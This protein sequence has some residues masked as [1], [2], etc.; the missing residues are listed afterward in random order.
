MHRK[1]FS[2]LIFSLCDN[3]SSQEK[4]HRFASMQ[5][6]SPG[7]SCMLGHLGCAHNLETG[8]PSESLSLSEEDVE[9]REHQEDI[10]QPE[11]S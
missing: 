9:D 10:P 2:P 5:K 3:L 6:Q 4:G 7:I 1:S 8:R 11:T